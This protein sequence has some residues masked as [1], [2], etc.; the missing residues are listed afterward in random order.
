MITTDYSRM[1]QILEPS[2]PTALAAGLVCFWDQLDPLLF[3]VQPTSQAGQT[4]LEEWRLLGC[5]VV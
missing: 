3:M 4:L 2:A 5:Y 1:E